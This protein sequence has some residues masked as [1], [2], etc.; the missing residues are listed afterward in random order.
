MGLTNFKYGVGSYGIPV[1]PSMQD[2]IFL[3]NVYFVDSGHADKGDTTS[4][5]TMDAPFSTIDYAI[6]RCTA[7]NGDV[8]LVAP[9]HAETIAA[10]GGIT[11]DVAGVTIIFCG[12]GES[13][14]IISFATATAASIVVSANNCKFV[15]GVFKCNIA[16]QNHMFD[17]KAK[18]F[19][20]DGCEFREGTATGLSFVTADTADA[21]S[22]RL[23]VRNCRFHAPTAG[24]MDNAIQLGKDFTGARIYN[25]EFY[26]DFDDACIDIPAGGNA[27]IDCVIKGCTL[28]NLLAGAYAIKVNGTGSTG[29][30]I[31]CKVETNAIATA[32]DA[33]GLEM[34][35]VYYHD[36]TDQI[37]WSPIASQPDS[38]QNIL[39]ADDN[40]NGFASTNVAINDDGSVLERLEYLQRSQ[41]IGSQ[42]Y[43]KKTL[44]SSAITQAGVDITGVS[45]GGDLW[46]DDIVVQTDGTGLATGTNFQVTNN[47]TKGG[48]VN[49]A[50]AVA[51]LGAS[52]TVD[53][54]G[55]GV[56]KLRGVL[57][58][59]KKL[60]AKSTA[61]DCT[62]GGTIDVYIKFTRLA[63]GATIAAA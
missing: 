14:G 45:S 8:I 59:G 19:T 35:E 53:M 54:A 33:G 2:N 25:S 5:G 43:V 11:L 34:F 61:A 51:S 47:N 41:N 52:V 7:N 37:G 30:I 26:G 32:V 29:K 57:E 49:F 4:N 20:L 36:G 48:A 44:T 10:A 22:D 9:G 60:V 63:S 6:G 55:A 27:Q 12:S 13:R 39:G 23:M 3:G 17:V 50:H 21:D 46:I 62:G 28:T 42:F 24:N 38:T 18:D 58:S 56:T 40:D 16:S 1:L 15:N 31:D